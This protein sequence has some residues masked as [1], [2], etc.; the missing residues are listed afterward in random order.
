MRSDPPALL[1]IF[2]SRLQGELLAALLLHPTRE[3]TLSDLATRLGAPLSTLH[4]EVKRL[5]EAGLIE[6]RREGRNR[7]VRS[8]PDHPA[9]PALTSL[10]ELTFGPRLV[11]AEE[12]SP[13]EAD[14]VVIFGSWAQRYQGEPGPP[15]GDIDVL[16]VGDVGR[17]AVYEAADR[18]Q[19]RLGL[20]VNPVLFSHER[21]SD[22]DDLLAGQIR[23]MPFVTVI[24]ARKP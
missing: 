1:P 7:L 3:Y 20:E 6:D 11:V 2:R 16:V 13:L 17:V 4:N 14:L 8:S 5:R 21:W 23:S 22:P 24:P 12:F 15:P 19:A 9:T 10:I 18:A